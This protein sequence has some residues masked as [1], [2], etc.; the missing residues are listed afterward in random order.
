MPDNA[1][2]G[3]IAISGWF[4]VALTWIVC[5]YAFLCWKQW[6]ASSLL[7]TMMERGYTPHEITQL[8]QV[9]GQRPASQKANFDLPPAKPIKQPAYAANY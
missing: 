2:I 8:F 3:V 9:L 7:R 6:H 4:C 1:I 5:H